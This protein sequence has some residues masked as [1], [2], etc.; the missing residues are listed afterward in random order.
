MLRLEQTPQ[1]I[2]YRLL[3]RKKVLCKGVLSWEE[4]QMVV[5]PHTNQIYIEN[6]CLTIDANTIETIYPP[7]K[8]EEWMDRPEEKIVGTINWGKIQKNMKSYLVSLEE[9]KKEKE[10]EN[11]ITNRELKRLFF[12]SI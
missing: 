2:E 6:Q 5:Y 3:C 11:K 7:D 4:W 8:Q 12:C 9:Q 1:G 10:W